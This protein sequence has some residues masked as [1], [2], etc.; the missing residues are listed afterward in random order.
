MCYYFVN[1][2][3]GS[4]DF[5]K[6][7]WLIDGNKERNMVTFEY[8]DKTWCMR[9]GRTIA[10]KYGYTKPTFMYLYYRLEKNEFLLFDRVFHKIIQNSNG[11]RRE[12]EKSDNS[13]VDQ[14]DE[15][16]EEEDNEGSDE[17]EE[18]DDDEDDE[19]EVD[20]VNY[21]DFEIIVSHSLANTKQVFVSI[22][23][24]VS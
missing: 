13:D 9:D 24:I 14:T 18:D 20:E 21:H 16:E 1:N 11:I 15:D 17:N 23:L 5:S 12:E 8:V 22:F 2:F 4:L 3:I 6:P 19:D 10:R 7:G